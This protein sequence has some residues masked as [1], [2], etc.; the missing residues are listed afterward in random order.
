MEAVIPNPE[1]APCRRWP[2]YDVQAPVKVTLWR[3]EKMLKTQGNSLKIGGG[4]L[5]LFVGTELKPQ[6]KIGLEFTAPCTQASV[7]IRGTVK[8]RAG[9]SYGIEF[10]LEDNDDLTAIEIIRAGLVGLAIL[11]PVAY[12]A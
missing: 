4:G 6:T 8:N 5:K 1:N 2:R 12:S 9:F 7:R 11:Q 10:L 3:G